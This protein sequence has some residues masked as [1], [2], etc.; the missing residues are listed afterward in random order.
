M[1]K[2]AFMVWRL[3]LLRFGGGL[4]L[5]LALLLVGGDAFWFLKWEGERFRGERSFVGWGWMDDVFLR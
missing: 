4:V 2:S 1:F 5:V 3:R